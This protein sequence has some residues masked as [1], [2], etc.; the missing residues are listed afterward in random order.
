MSNMDKIRAAKKAIKG[1]G[2]Q[3]KLASC[4]VKK[5]PELSGDRALWRVQKWSYNGIPPKF[6]AVVEQ[7][8]GVPRHQLCPEIFSEAL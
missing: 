8:S 6:A 7:C 2:G 5:F 4:I 1:A 3:A